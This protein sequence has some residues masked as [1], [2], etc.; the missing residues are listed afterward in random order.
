MQNGDQAMNL[1]ENEFAHLFERLKIDDA[2]RP[3]HR[4]T[5][6][7][8]VLETYDRVAEPIPSLRR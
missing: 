7:K 3:E 6:R 1:D 2:P 8:Q 4:E 5:L